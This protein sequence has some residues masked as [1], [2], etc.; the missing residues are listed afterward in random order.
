MIGYYRTLC[1]LTDGT[2]L[3][4]HAAFDMD[5]KMEVSDELKFI[6]IGHIFSTGYEAISY[7]SGIKYRFYVST[8]PKRI[9]ISRR[10][11]R[12]LINELRNNKE[13]EE[14]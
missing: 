5:S 10:L 6:G 1:L 2:I 14:H 13:R 3:P 12:D 8:I 9:K 4:Y 11:H 7:S